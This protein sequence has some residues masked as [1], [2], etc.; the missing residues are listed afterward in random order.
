M[1]TPLE[2]LILIFCYNFNFNSKIKF[3]HI[4]E[5]I[6]NHKLHL[7]L[8]FIL[9]FPYFNFNLS[10]QFFKYLTRYLN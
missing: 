6:I 1:Y 7:T 4:N 2:N 10:Y 3:K 5:D 9:M 8:D